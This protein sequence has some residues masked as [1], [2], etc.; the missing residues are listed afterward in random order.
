MSIC[1]SGHGLT[2]EYRIPKQEADVPDSLLL[3]SGFFHNDAHHVKTLPTG[4][5]FQFNV[6]PEPS[7]QVLDNRGSKTVELLRNQNC[8]GW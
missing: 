3:L 5:Q 1:G 8:C 4:K 7:L 6:H 2:F